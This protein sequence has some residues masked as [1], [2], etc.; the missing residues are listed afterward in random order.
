[1]TGTLWRL[2]AE[3]QA[4]DLRA[5]SEALTDMESS[6]ALA[7]SVFEHG[8]GR[9]LLEALFDHAPDAGSFLRSAGLDP[10]SLYDVH[11]G[12]LPNEDWVALSLRGLKPVTA[13]RFYVHGS[14]DA[15]AGEVPILIEANLAFGTGHH[16]TTRGCLAAFDTLLAAGE[17]FRN[18]LDLGCGA[19]TLAIAAARTTAAEVTASDNDPVAIDVTLENMEANAAPAIRTVVAEGLKDARLAKAAPYDLIFANILAGPLVELSAGIADALARGGR[20]ILSGLLV[21]QRD[22]VAEAYLAAGL[23][24]ESEMQI[25]G[26][27]TI[28]MRRPA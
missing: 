22:M 7:V 12:P 8:P 23:T 27:S 28:V 14:H 9:A 20:V 17:T 13:G 1:M 2:A 19:G 15:P 5:A 21:E 3:G 10:A 16:G 25:D 4:A 6:T 11:V 18:V 26:W 24:L